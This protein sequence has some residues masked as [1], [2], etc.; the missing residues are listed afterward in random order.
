MSDKT[1][2]LNI[3]RLQKYPEHF[4]TFKN[5][6]KTVLQKIG[7]SNKTKAIHNAVEKDIINLGFGTTDISGRTKSEFGSSLVSDVPNPKLII[8][9]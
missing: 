7:T 2:Q 6:L 9:F 1:I 4:K 5:N 3:L 8:S